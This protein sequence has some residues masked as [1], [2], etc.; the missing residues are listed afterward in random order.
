MAAQGPHCPGVAEDCWRSTAPL[1][2]GDPGQ[3]LAQGG[4]GARDEPAFALVLG[5]GVEVRGFEPLASSV[6]W[7]E[8]GFEQL[9][10]CSDQ[11]SSTPL[12]LLMG[13]IPPGRRNMTGTPAGTCA[14]LRR[15]PD[16]EGVEGEGTSP[17]LMATLRLLN[18]GPG[19]SSFA[20]QER[21]SGSRD[22]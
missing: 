13:L 18:H 7:I 1:A 12:L 14:Q 20:G 8:R 19:W 3:Q 9:E 5:G 16:V 21:M 15:L 2:A 6:R 10:Q 4:V 11:H 22:A 17:R